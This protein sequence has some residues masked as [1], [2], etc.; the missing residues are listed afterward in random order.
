MSPSRADDPSLGVTRNSTSPLPCPEA[1]DNPK[2]QFTALDTFHAHSG[3]VVIDSLAVPPPASTFDGVASDTGH[4]T[5]SAPVGVTIVVEDELQPAVIAA[6]TR[7]MPANTPGHPRMRAA[8]SKSH[9]SEERPGRAWVVHRSLPD[10]EIFA[11][12]RPPFASVRR[13]ERV[14]QGAVVGGRVGRLVARDGRSRTRTRPIEPCPTPRQ[15]VD[16]A[17]DRDDTNTNS[18]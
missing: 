12:A 10:M 1:G 17:D 18:C 11:S 16:D 4:L 2:I 3:C 6:A 8:P 9:S 7:I 13:R 14:A 5:D 15:S